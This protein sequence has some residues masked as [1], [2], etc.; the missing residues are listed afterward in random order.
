[1]KIWIVVTWVMALYIV[2]GGNYRGK[3]LPSFSGYN[4][5]WRQQIALKH[6]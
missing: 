2:M 5:R 4:W 6:Y 1:V 3:L